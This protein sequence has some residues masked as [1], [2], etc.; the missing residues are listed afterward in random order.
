MRRIVLISSLAILVILLVYLIINVLKPPVPLK[1]E[2]IDSNRN[3]GKVIDALF[4]EYYGRDPKPVILDDN[5]LKIYNGPDLKY[6]VNS[7][8]L[9][10]SVIDY[11]IKNAPNMLSFDNV[12]ITLICK[13]DL[14]AKEVVS[15]VFTQKQMQISSFK[16][17]EYVEFSTNMDKIINLSYSKESKKFYI[18]CQ[19]DSLD[20]ICIYDSDG[21]IIKKQATQKMLLSFFY[22]N[23]FNTSTIGYDGKC[24]YFFR[25]DGKGFS[26][27]EKHDVGMQGNLEDSLLNSVVDM[28]WVYDG[29]LDHIGLY[30]G[31]YLHIFD[32]QKKTF[33]DK[34]N[35]GKVSRSLFYSL[36]SS[37]TGIY[38]VNK[39]ENKFNMSD[40]KLTDLIT[41]DLTLFQCFHGMNY[42]VGSFTNNKQ[43]LHMLNDT[44]PNNGDTID[45]FKFEDIP[46]KVEFII[47]NRSFPFE[48]YFYTKNQVLKFSHDNTSK[49]DYQNALV[50]KIYIK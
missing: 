20:N 12:I 40:L 42:I 29:A 43:N 45:V 3:K 14:N 24:L 39:N 17:Y 23:D 1:L 22:N 35:I 27:V 8:K 38:Y 6:I 30:D 25:V 36:Y 37:N 50:R 21:T 48:I 9:P 41:P 13:D 26:E 2:L 33:V 5:T 44:T 7:I 15:I 16:E 34:Y 28:Y 31:T 18:L 10:G 11:Y 32:M 4:P 19:S 47:H 46:Q 49:R